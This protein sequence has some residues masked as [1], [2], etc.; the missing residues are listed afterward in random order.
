MKKDYGRIVKILWTMTYHNPGEYGLFWDEDNTMP[1]KELYW[2]CVAEPRLSIISRNFLKE[3]ALL[4]YDL[5]FVVEESRLR[6]I[7]PRPIYEITNPPER[8]YFAARLSNVPFISEKGILVPAHRSYIGLWSNTEKSLRYGKPSR[9]DKIP[10]VVDTNI[11]RGSG[12]VFLHGGHDFFLTSEEIPMEAIHIPPIT[13]RK[14]QGLREKKERKGEKARLMEEKQKR[15]T[16]GSF[17][18]DVEYFQSLYGRKMAEISRETHTEMKG[19]KQ[20]KGPAW[21]KEVRKIRKTKRTV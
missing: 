17:Y 8:L 1:W 21:K 12:I 10:I 20:H 19:K 11:A 4:G 16:P 13:E 3:L 6:L 15:D 7:Q 9:E 18:P 14:K 2:I 5:P